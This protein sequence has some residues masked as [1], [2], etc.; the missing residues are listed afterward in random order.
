MVFL[1]ENVAEGE[2]SVALPT[3]DTN[4]QAAFLANVQAVSSPDILVLTIDPEDAEGLGGPEVVYV[5]AHTASATNAT[6]TRGQE[7]TSD[8]GV[9]WPIGTKVVAGLTAAMMEDLATDA[10]L[11]AGLADHLT[12]EFTEHANFARTD[13]ATTQAFT[14]GI[15]VGNDVNGDGTLILAG[16]EGGSD[17]ITI[18]PSDIDLAIN[19]TTVLAAGTSDVVFNVQPKHGADII[20]DRGDLSS[21]TPGDVAQSGTGSAGVSTDVS[22]ADHTHGINFGGTA[23]IADIG[24]VEAAGTDNRAARSD[25][26]H[27]IGN[28]RAVAIDGGVVYDSSGT[29]TTTATNHAVAAIARP[30][31]WGSTKVLVFGG[32]QIA[33][34][35]A[36]GQLNGRVEIDGN[37]SSASQS[38]QSDV[39]EGINDRSVSFAHSYVTTDSTINIHAELYLTGGATTSTLKHC[40]LQ[41]ILIRAS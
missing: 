1:Y 8:P 41:Y 11:T 24:A 40:V 17:K 34:M 33:A 29:I 5:T 16:T 38:G 26:V 20:L 7:S 10:A 9:S 32:A 36:D 12:N 25:H 27:E 2:L 39:S 28:A 14:G 23:Q 21:A 35:D 37:T 22:R 6:V 15:T 4:L 19:G 18:G 3:T 31:G 13:T 30:T